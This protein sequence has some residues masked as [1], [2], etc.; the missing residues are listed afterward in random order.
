M[1]IYQIIPTIFI[2]EVEFPLLTIWLGSGTTPWTME[3]EVINWKKE[4]E[5]KK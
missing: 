2:V 5:D 4:L 3:E 1:I